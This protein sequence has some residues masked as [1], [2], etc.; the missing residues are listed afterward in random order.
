[1]KINV[2][3]KYVN[4]KVYKKK[5]LSANYT[6]QITILHLFLNSPVY[7]NGGCY[8]NKRSFDWYKTL[9]AY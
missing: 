9:L 5:Y 1:M 4:E 2:F 7:V 3:L 6:Y 8:V